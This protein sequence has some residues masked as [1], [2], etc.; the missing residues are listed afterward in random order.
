MDRYEWDEAKYQANLRKHG[1]AFELV[2]DFD[3]IGAFVEA[4][5]RFDYG[6]ERF[7]AYGRV[8]E[9]GYALVFVRRGDRVR[10]ISLRPAHEKEMRRY[11]V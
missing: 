5:Q 9:R 10:I 1:T 8:G 11:D 6:E 4:D 2:Y 3:W 7:V